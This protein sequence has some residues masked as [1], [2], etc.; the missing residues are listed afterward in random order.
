[1]KRATA[2]SNKSSVSVFLQVWLLA[3]ML[4]P[5]SGR[6]GMGRWSCVA[7]LALARADGA[8]LP[9]LAGLGGPGSGRRRSWRPFLARKLIPGAVA[10]GPVLP[11]P[12]SPAGRGGEGRSG[13][14]W[15]PLACPR[16]QPGLLKLLLRQIPSGDEVCRRYPWPRGPCRTSA[17]QAPRLSFFLQAVEPMRR[18]LDL[19]TAIHPGGEPSG[20]V[21]GVAAKGRRPRLRC[22]SDGEEGLDRFSAPPSGVLLV[23]FKDQLFLRVLF[24]IVSI[25]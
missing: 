19:D 23:K 15:A 11:R 21:P 24:V 13:W 18:I 7:G 9:P 5:L 2:P 14:V 20:I 25:V 8:L 1:V 22:A 17:A 16:R 10:C 3:A 6:G 12:P 4:S